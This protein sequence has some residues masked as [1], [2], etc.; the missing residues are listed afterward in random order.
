MISLLWKSFY[1]ASAYNYVLK[2]WKFKT[3]I[4]FFF[5][6]LIA[7][8]FANLGSIPYLYNFLNDEAKTISSQIP[9]CKITETGF[10][11][12]SD[13]PLYVKLSN[14]K[15]F[16]GFSEN[17]IPSEK[18]ENLLFA[19]ERDWISFNL[20]DGF[21]KRVPYAEILQYYKTIYPNETEILINPDTSLK[22]I[23]YLKGVT[24]LIF[25]A[26][27]FAF[28]IMT[29]T[30]MLFSVTIP[31][32]LLSL[33]L[34]PEI[35]LTGAIKI[36]LIASTPAIILSSIGGLF[37]N[38]GSFVFAMLSFVIVWKMMRRIAIL[39]IEENLKS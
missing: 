37:S 16:I 32:Y 11:F 34:M 39:R 36:A 28:A 19:F 26:F 35:K 4:Y 2:T 18:L 25:P 24:L 15:D 5:V 20:T 17:F 27:N 29:S 8:I 14:G 9:N 38:F 30:L 21:E 12:K 22:F 10:D 6:S 23:E 31:T 7:S 13:T 3:V 1:D 33:N